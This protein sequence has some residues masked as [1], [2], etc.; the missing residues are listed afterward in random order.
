[1]PTFSGWVAEK[2]VTI[3]GQTLKEAME[4]AGYLPLRAEKSGGQLVGQL[5][6]GQRFRFMMQPRLS[7]FNFRKDRNY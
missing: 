3:Q 6:T 4:F 2:R 5:I 1:M 7:Q